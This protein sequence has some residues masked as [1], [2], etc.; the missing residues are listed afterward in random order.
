MRFLGRERVG[1]REVA[2]AARRDERGSHPEG[3]RPRSD[4]GGAGSADSPDH[5]AAGGRPDGSDPR[6]LVARCDH[7]G[8]ITLSRWG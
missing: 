8:F 6:A 7:P 2:G 5:R 3:G 1:V 4:Q